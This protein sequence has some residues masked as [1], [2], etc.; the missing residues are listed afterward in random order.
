MSSDLQ[1]IGAITLF[2][3]DLRSC[4]AFY[5]KVFAA[6]AVHEDE[7]SA[8]FDFDGTL[9]NLL[10]VSEAHGLIAPAAV[11]GPEA[12]ARVQLSIWVEDADATCA[13]LRARGLALL[14]G[15]MDREWGKR[16]ATFADPAGHI[17]EIA[18]DISP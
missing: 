6:A 17:W 16:T 12:G 11:A 7:N 4:K 5:E 10:D 2:V 9:V 3:E 15:P 14:S 18:Q 13:E 1:S 8:V